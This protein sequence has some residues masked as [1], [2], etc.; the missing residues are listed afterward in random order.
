MPR[1]S[2]PNW[3]NSPGDNVLIDDDA[4]CRPMTARELNLTLDDQRTI[5]TSD[6]LVET[7]KGICL[8]TYV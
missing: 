3:P 2:K 4:D 5:V 7:L 6:T 1:T 8:Q